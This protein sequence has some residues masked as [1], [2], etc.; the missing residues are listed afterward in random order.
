M[1]CVE[2]G[3]EGVVGAA[4]AAAADLVED[5]GV[6]HGGGDVAVAE[7]L[8]DGTDV[9]AISEQ[10]GGKRVAERVAGDALRE[11]GRACSSGDGS[12][13]EAAVQVVPVD[14]AGAGVGREGAGGEDPLPAP[15]PCGAG[16]LAGKGVGEP[17][18][19]VAGVNVGGVLLATALEVLAELVDE[20]TG[21]HR[22]AVLAALAVAHDDQL[23]AEV[24]V[25]DAQAEG[26]HEAEAGAVEQVGDEPVLPV[27]VG[28][29]LPDCGINRV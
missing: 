18:G 24:D 25:L 27:H 3:G 17:D 8:L 1:G 12:L 19:A 29:E 13:W 7:E 4:D 11:S 26:L 21:E 2:G 15:V 16:V 5:V 6:D 10:V 14:L 20:R 22:A 9:V 28:E 23:Q